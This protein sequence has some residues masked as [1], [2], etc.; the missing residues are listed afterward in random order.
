MEDMLSNRSLFLAA[1][2]VVSAGLCSSAFATAFSAN[3]LVVMRCTNGT[4]AEMVYLDEYDVSGAA[5]AL[6]QTIAMPSTG[7]DALT[8]PG[9]MSHDRHLHRSTD[10]RFLTLTGYNM[11]YGTTDPS[12]TSSTTTPRM[13]CLVKYDGTYDLST[14]L[15]D[16]YNNTM[17]RSAVTTDGTKFWLAG[18]NGGGTTN[19]GGTRFATL[20][21]SATVNLS[22][23][24]TEPPSGATDNVREIGIF[25]GQLYNSSGSSSSIGKALLQVGSGLPE[26]GS[27]PLTKLTTDG[28]ST[29][30]FYLIDAD[31]GVPGVD[32]AY[33]AAG[34]TI[35][36]YSLVSGAWAA[37]GYITVGGECDQIAV[38]VDGMGQATIYTGQTGGIYRLTD[39][40]P[41][42]G[43]LSGNISGSAAYIAAPQGFTLGGVDFAP[44]PEPATLALLGMA[45]TVLLTGRRRS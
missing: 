6:V 24:Q 39:S 27:Q 19:T 25:G 38:A 17:I 32:T 1:V 35:R 41:Y 29:S 36:K 16:A 20:G 42:G 31:P 9:T 21:S 5:P 12:T 8:T 30:S 2:I 28:Q 4:G 40:S 23:T 22:K 33:T 43:T 34:T 45:G 10:G 3:N 14:K 11:A 15:T 7:S 26:S 37:R 18:D 13:V 44:V